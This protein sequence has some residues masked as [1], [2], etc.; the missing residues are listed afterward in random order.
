MAVVPNN[1]LL[2]S[3][4][5]LCQ[6]ANT[7]MDQLSITEDNSTI[8]EVIPLNDELNGVPLSRVILTRNRRDVDIPQFAP[9]PDEIDEYLEYDFPRQNILVLVDDWGTGDGTIVLTVSDPTDPVEVATALQ[10]AT[11]VSF[12]STD[13]ADISQIDGLARYTVKMSEYSAY[14]YGSFVLVVST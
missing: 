3:K 11:N 13:F 8:E 1:F 4:A 5:L 14:Y 7:K 2:S 9:L 6:Y 10:D 12:T